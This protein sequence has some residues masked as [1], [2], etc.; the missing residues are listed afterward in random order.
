[1]SSETFLLLLS[2]VRAHTCV[3]KCVK[4]A[5]GKCCMRSHSVSSH[6]YPPDLLETWPVEFGPWFSF[7][8]GLLFE[9]FFVWS[10]KPRGWLV[11]L[12]LWGQGRGTIEAG[13]GSG[14]A[15]RTMANQLGDFQS[16]LQS[17]SEGPG[18]RFPVGEVTAQKTGA[19]VLLQLGI[20]LPICLTELIV[21]PF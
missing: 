8:S 12:Y 19:S 5:R 2:L 4:E 18:R 11:L 14:V 15:W 10:L 16:D 7:S 3:C 9:Q 21:Q 13:R 6:L 17:T 1:M 20:P